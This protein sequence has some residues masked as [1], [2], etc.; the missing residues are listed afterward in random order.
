MTSR[1]TKLEEVNL[2]CWLALGMALWRDVTHSLSLLVFV[3]TE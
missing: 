1:D 2:C 3:E